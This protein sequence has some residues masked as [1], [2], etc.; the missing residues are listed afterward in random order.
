MILIGA[1]KVAH[2]R[3]RVPEAEIKKRLLSDLAAKWPY[4]NIIYIQTLTLCPTVLP[5]I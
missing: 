1:L 5:N 3:E 4:V 2:E